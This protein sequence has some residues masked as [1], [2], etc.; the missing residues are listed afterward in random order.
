M[1][2]TAPPVTRAPAPH[3][4]DE[5]TLLEGWLDYQRQTL[6]L[7]CAGLT[8]EQLKTASVA[9]SHLSLLGL[10]RHL[11]YVERVW[12]RRGAAGQDVPNLYC[13]EERPDTDFE[14]VAGA[15]AE[16]DVAAFWAEVAAARAA[17][18]DRSLEDSFQGYRDGGTHTFTLRWAYL[19]MIEEYARHNGHA[20]LLRERVDGA[21][22]A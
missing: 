6:L 12:F 16:A 20:D 8:A 11:A 14:D 1:T 21:I 22:G 13:T 9:P 7:K 4:G 18:A 3:I 2:W 10:V 15:D 17:V 19:H 5:R